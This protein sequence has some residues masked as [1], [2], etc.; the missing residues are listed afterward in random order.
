MVAGRVEG[1]YRERHFDMN[2]LLTV[3]EAE[4]GKVPQCQ[5]IFEKCVFI[6]LYFIFFLSVVSTN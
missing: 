6:S 2:A 4:S 1:C 3:E 5:G